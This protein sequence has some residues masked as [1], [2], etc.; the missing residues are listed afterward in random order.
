MNCAN[1]QGLIKILFVMKKTMHVLKKSVS[2]RDLMDDYRSAECRW[3]YA[4]CATA[5]AMARGE[6][7]YIALLLERLGYT[8]SD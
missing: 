2:V 8:I 5:R 6:M 4:D 7:L 3:R 1:E